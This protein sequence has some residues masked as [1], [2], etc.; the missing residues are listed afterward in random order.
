MVW[1]NLNTYVSR[2]ERELVAAWGGLTV[3]QLA[4]CA[5][6]LNAVE[7]LSQLNRTIGG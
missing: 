1:D 4:P 5:C 7:D 6:E 3:L 2:A